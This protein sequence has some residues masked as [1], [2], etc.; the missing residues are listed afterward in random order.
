MAKS[1]VKLGRLDKSAVPLDEQD[2]L[3]ILNQAL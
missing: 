1:A 3:H 2:V